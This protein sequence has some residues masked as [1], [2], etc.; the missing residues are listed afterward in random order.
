MEGNGTY[1]YANGSRYEGEFKN[2]VKDG[3]GIETDVN[4]K[5]TKGI[6]ENGK[7]IWEQ[8]KQS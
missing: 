8:N 3:N 1:F 4:G 5:Q 6:W 2:D 7:R